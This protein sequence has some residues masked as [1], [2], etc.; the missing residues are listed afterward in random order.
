MSKARYTVT[1]STNGTL[2]KTFLQYEGKNSY[3]EKRGVNKRK[4]FHENLKTTFNKA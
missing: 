2:L 1:G 4:Y 3:E